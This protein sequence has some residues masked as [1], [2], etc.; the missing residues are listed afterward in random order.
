MRRRECVEQKRSALVWHFREVALG[1]ASKPLA[2]PFPLPFR[3]DR[4]GFHADRFGSDGA[5]R[6]ARASPRDEFSLAREVDAE[7][8]EF[9]AKELMHTLW[10]TLAN[11]PCQVRVAREFS[12]RWRRA[13]R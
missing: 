12:T 4:L 13:P 3:A 9:K 10:Q 8:G 7:Y 1:I 2:L 11:L 6:R 5:A